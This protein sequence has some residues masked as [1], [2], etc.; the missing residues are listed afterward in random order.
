MSQAPQPSQP[1]Q[2]SQKPQPSQAASGKT[3]DII[4]WSGSNA[5]NNGVTPTFTQV[6]AN[7]MYDQTI[8]G[9][10]NMRQI[11]AGR[12]PLTNQLAV[13]LS[14]EMPANQPGTRVGTREMTTRPG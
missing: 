2:A 3:G 14:T 13:N 1:P 6:T 11:L 9:T 7:R 5:A 10:A 8:Y 12:A 4:V